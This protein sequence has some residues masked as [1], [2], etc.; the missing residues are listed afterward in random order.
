MKTNRIALAIL[1]AL[2]LGACA[3]TSTTTTTWGDPNGGYW[4]RR[5]SVTSIRE[6]VTRQ[7]GNPAG[8]AVAGAVI[9]GLLGSAIGGHTEYDR[10]GRA[11]YQGNPAG[12]VFGAVGGAMVGA[13][14]SQ[15]GPERRTYEV[16]VQFEDGAQQS[17]AYDGAPPFR[18]GDPV[19]LTPQGL[20]GG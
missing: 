11:Y 10:W 13:A 20:Y 17:Y 1:P 8:G 16:L 2:L 4:E 15:G 18:V 14:A 9:G 6:T 3:T 12:A 19:R 7:Q 5:G